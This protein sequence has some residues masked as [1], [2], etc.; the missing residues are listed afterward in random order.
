MCIVILIPGTSLYIVSVEIDL[1][2]GGKIP[3][4]LKCISNN[5]H[6]N[7]IK[8]KS[9]TFNQFDRISC[10]CFIF[11]H[12]LLSQCIISPYKYR[13]STWRHTIL[14]NEDV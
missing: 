8:V 13:I 12:T 11:G 10:C 14:G 7:V 5:K 9:L 2:P 4:Y 6:W 3:T 1:C